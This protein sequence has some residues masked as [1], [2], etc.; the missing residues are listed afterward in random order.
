MEISPFM[1]SIDDDVLADLRGRLERTRWPNLIERTKWSYGVPGDWLWRLV[2]YW[3]NDFDWRA[4]EAK[5]N[6]WPQFIASTDDYNVHFL[7]A[8]SAEPDAAPLV[9][10]IGWPSTF[11]ETIPI[12]DRLTDPAAHG[13]DSRDAF[14]VIVPTI[15]GFGFSTP[16]SVEGW[17]PADDLWA[18]LMSRLGYDRFFAAGSDWGSQI[19]NQLARRHSD[20]LLGVHYSSPDL[21]LPNPIPSSVAA[22]ANDYLRRLETWMSEEGGYQAIQRTKPQT[23]A[24][25]LSDSPAGLAAWLLEKVHAW[26]ADESSFDKDDLLTTATIYWA[27]NTAASAARIYYEFAHSGVL[28][29]DPG[30]RVA[31]PTGVLTFPQGA[32]PNLPRPLIEHSYDISRWT[33][34]PVGGHFPAFETPEL[35]ASELR[36]FARPLRA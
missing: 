28:R 27:T 12:L 21:E 14:H 6:E 19:T 1:V 32:E 7:H 26:S 13:G 22:C 8:R 10:T 31:V 17:V 9:L 34:A 33:D 4:I 18:A 5:L 15:P 36:E 20:R 16:L 29:L 30:E 3:I 24:F 23:L 11:A 2:D 35:L 25:A